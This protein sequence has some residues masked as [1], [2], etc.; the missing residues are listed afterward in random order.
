MQFKNEIDPRF[1]SASGTN[2]F[3]STISPSRLVMYYGHCGQRLVIEG[4]NTSRLESGA[5]REYGKYTF[6]IKAPCDMRVVKVIER[7][8]LTIGMDAIHDNPGT[9]VIYENDATGEFGFLELPKYRSDHQHFGFQYKYKPNWRSDILVPNTYV[10]KGTVIA[11]SPAVDDLG[12]YNYGISVPTALM[13]VPAIIEDG[14][15]V[16]DALLPLLKTKAYETHV[17]SFGKRGFPLNLY[18][19]DDI[20][21]ICPDI[22]EHVAKDGLLFAW[23]E[24][25]ALLGPVQLSKRALSRK[26]VDPIY[27]KK[28]YVKPGAK[29]IDIK[30]YHEVRGNGNNSQIP[31]GTTGQLEKYRNAQQRYADTLITEYES[32]QKRY[33]RK[34]KISPAMED[35]LV[36]A[37]AYRGVGSNG[38]VKRTYRADPLDEWRVEVV[39]EYDLIPTIGFK[40]TGRYGDKGVICNIRKHEDMPIDAAGNRAMAIMDAN[41]TIKRMNPGRTYEQYIN[42]CSRDLT[43]E[44][45]KRYAQDTSDANVELLWQ[46]IIRYYEIC[47]PRMHR[48][49]T[50][51]N[52][53]QSHRQ[54]VE[55]IVR[56][57]IYLRKMTDDENSIITL[58]DTLRHEYPPVHGPV[59]YRGN[60]GI[61]RRTK[62][63]IIIG[64]MY[65]M[66]LEKT[67]MDWSGVASAKR[68]HFGMAAKITNSD[69]YSDPGR[70]QPIRLPGEAE[71]RLMSAASD[72]LPR[73]PAAE[74]IEM[75]SNPQTHRVVCESL[76][77]TPHPT[78]IKQ[79]VDR[80]KYPLGRHRAQE[81]IRNSAEAAGWKF[82]KGAY[83]D[84]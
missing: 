32:M 1:A 67:G 22:G 42:A 79:V 20:Y 30:V 58:I 78:K 33:G 82:V 74:I 15:E 75:S 10:K 51:V 27:D 29:V 11:D 37:Q 19:T 47:S 25:N 3:M 5:D 26:G 65:L 49:I 17:V 63:R 38:K 84:V 46:R 43:A 61:W 36:S 52:Y 8:P 56:D 68:S 2:P 28:H 64:D 53:M 23:R 76:M 9:I 13:S 45:R 24:H 70:A 39:I 34:L 77:Q 62:K 35:L 71:S 16:S 81:L 80:V 59:E 41:S 57:G 12:N 4:A 60:S 14:I 73:N 54:H 44:I 31:Q 18:G 7:Y 6:K 72:G 83:D 66:L 50:S 48:I 69:K 40:M 55:E 21:K